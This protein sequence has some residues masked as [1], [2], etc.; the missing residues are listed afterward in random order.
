MYVLGIAH[1][2]GKETVPIC[3]EDSRHL[4]DIP[5]THTIEY[6]DRYSGRM[7]LLNMLSES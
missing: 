3:P 2:V 7:K 5:K 4:V 6:E 1:T